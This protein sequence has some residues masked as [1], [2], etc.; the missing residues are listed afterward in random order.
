MSK[1]VVLLE[2]TNTDFEKVGP[3]VPADGWYGHVDGLYT[4]AIY[5]D[6]FIGRIVIEGS[7]VSEPS[8]NDWFPIKIDKCKYL[9]FPRNPT[10]PTG[11]GNIQGDSGI[12]GFTFHA[13]IV[14]IRARI[15]RDYLNISREDLD[16]IEML[17]IV[18]KI[19]VSR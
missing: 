13:N 10:A 15:E 11:H 18:N 16:E 9:E 17:G 7:I 4:L 2:N 5:L 3:A 19:L 1:T 12:I 14:W 8:E 6:N